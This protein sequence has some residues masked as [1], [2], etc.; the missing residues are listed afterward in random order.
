MP[1][2]MNFGGSTPPEIRGNVT[3]S[4]HVGWIE[5]ESAQFGVARNKTAPTGRREDDRPATSEIVV[6]KVH[7]VSSTG[8][9]RESLQGKGKKVVIDFVKTDKGKPEVYLTITLTDVLVS[10]YNVGGHGG[11]G[12]KN[13]PMESLTLN[14]AKVE[15]GPAK[16]VQPHTDP[17]PHQDMQAW[18][19]GG[20]AGQ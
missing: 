6:T 9:F 10:S 11:S 18:D 1:I 14:Y 17:T 4:N 13:L 19:L 2:Y 8:L 15:Y 7:D 16:G 20:A 5:L 3:E 12:P